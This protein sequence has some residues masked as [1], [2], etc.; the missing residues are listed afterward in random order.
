MKRGAKTPAQ[1]EEHFSFV[2]EA[3][4]LDKQL[5]ELGDTAVSIQLHFMHPLVQNIFTPRF[6]CLITLD[7]MN[8]SCVKVP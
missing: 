3:E 2:S 8:L 7:I 4:A 1:Q 5:Q 6:I